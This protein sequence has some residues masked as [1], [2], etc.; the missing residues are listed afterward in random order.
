[1][2]TFDYIFIVIIMLASG[3]ILYLN[4]FKGPEHVLQKIMRTLIWLI[5]ILVSSFFIYGTFS[6]ER[7]SIGDLFYDRHDRRIFLQDFSTV[8]GYLIF[9]FL[10]PLLVLYG[11]MNAYYTES[12]YQFKNRFLIGLKTTGVITIFVVIYSLL[13]FFWCGGGESCSWT[14]FFWLILFV[15]G[16]FL[17][18]LISGIFK[19]I[20]R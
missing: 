1:M 17:S 2:Q 13:G 14:L 19:F 16:A 18:F 4:W 7:F 20:K 6:G 3:T 15:E 10:L 5:P 9:Y 12:I 11:N 8:C